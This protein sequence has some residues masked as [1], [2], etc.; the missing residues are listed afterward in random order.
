VPLYRYEALDQ[1]G[2]KVVGAMQVD[3]EHA[4]AARLAQMGYRATMVQVAQRNLTQ[5]PAAAPAVT[6]SVRSGSHLAAPDREVARMLH[7]LHLAFKAG[8]PAFLSITTVAG[9]TYHAALRQILTEMGHSVQNGG[10]LSEAMAHFPRV[11]LPGD[12]GMIRAGELGGFLPEALQA[13]SARRE[14]DDNARGRLR[15][16][17]WFFHMNMVTLFFFLPVAWF[18]KDVFPSFDVKV[19]LAAAMRSLVF[20]SLPL[21]MGY[22][23]LVFWLGRS[24]VSPGARRQWHAL[25]LRLPLTGRLN[26]VRAKAAFTRS[27]AWLFH[28]GV[29]PATAWETASGAAPNLVLADQFRSAI[30]VIQSTGRAS[31]AIQVTGLMDPA[32]AGMVATGEATGEIPQALNYLANRYEEECRQAIQECVSKATGMFR[33]WALLLGALGFALVM[34][35]YGQGVVKI[36]GPEGEF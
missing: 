21:T 34:W 28:A 23:A 24:R 13:L 1:A 22:L 15:L 4:L 20:L 8:M 14:E 31:A 12:V 6:A 33:V 11:F 27:L 7:Q 36:G 2:T 17:V 26:R 19:G 9:Q 25:L 29:S 16:W 3:N 32:D 10:T 18:L 5:A 35:A 30:P